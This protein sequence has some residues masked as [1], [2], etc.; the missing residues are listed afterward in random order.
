VRKKRV[1]KEPVFT[2]AEEIRS[3]RERPG[4]RHNRKDALAVLAFLL[5]T[6]AI[7]VNALFLQSGS[8]PGPTVVEK[9]QRAPVR[10]AAV[11][12]TV[13]L[14][15]PR[16]IERD[17]VKAELVNPA[18]AAIKTSVA[19][20]APKIEPAHN[21]VTPSNRVLIVQRVLAEF[22]YGQIKATG[23]VDPDTRQAIEAFER[24]HKLPVTGAVSD[25]L[26][27]TMTAMTGQAFD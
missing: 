13:I 27:K 10:Q 17:V 7:V 18:P 20:P 4:P 11:T 15:R 12:G 22:G 24:Q 26:T 21:P 9:A 8:H 14:P 6:G 1:R 2:Q 3:A 23:V 5:A 19:S 25:R 16:P